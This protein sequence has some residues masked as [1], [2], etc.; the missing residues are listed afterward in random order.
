MPELSLPE[1]TYLI[2]AI[3]AFVSF[4]VSLFSVW[5]YVNSA[6]TGAVAVAE[7]AAQTPQGPAEVPPLR[8][9]A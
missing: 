2:G 1:M 8:E 3:A 6:P 9:A 4:G 7:Q 5:I